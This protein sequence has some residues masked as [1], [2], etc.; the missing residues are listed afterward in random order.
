MASPPN[1]VGQNA[2]MIGTAFFI[3]RNHLLTARHNLTDKH[4]RIVTRTASIATP[5]T[6]FVCYSEVLETETVISCHLI[7]EESQYD[8]DL[9][10]TDGYRSRHWLSLD[11]GGLSV[12]DHA[13]VIGYPCVRTDDWIMCHPGITDVIKARDVI[14]KL[15]PTGHLSFSAG[16]IQT[17]DESKCI[18]EYDASTCPGLSGGSIVHS[19]KVI[20]TLLLLLTI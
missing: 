3:D 8:I 15:L 4:D 19:G 12:G 18:F 20:G 16:T 7:A 2:K 5:G 9:L 6:P 17:T 1:S 14:T 10:K 13:T 11:D